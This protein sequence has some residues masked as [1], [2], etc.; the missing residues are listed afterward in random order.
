MTFDGPSQ[1]S[2]AFVHYK[3][4][5]VKFANIKKLTL[6]VH[7]GANCKD[8]LGYINENPYGFPW[9][10]KV[11]TVC[12]IDIADGDTKGDIKYVTKFLNNFKII[13]NLQW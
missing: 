6:T 11:E 13:E 2:G 7:S 3:N 8:I 5:L 1:H 10:N 12:L 4:V 9:W